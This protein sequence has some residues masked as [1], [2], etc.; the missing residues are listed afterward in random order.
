MG[1]H[2]C[3]FL[4]NVDNIH[5]QIRFSYPRMASPSMFLTDVDAKGVVL[6]YRSM[7]QGFLPYFIGTGHWTVRGLHSRP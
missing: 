6:V 4:G 2:F 5:Q 3:D 7:R 1:R